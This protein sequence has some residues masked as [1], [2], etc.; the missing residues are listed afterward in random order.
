M[1]DKYEE[2]KRKFEKDIEKFAE[3]LKKK[4]KILVYDSDKPRV[5]EGTVKRFN[6]W[7]EYCDGYWPG[8]IIEDD[9]GDYHWTKFKNLEEAEVL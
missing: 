1:F 8:V 4:V 7:E 6:T 3:F 2:R 9:D 5:I